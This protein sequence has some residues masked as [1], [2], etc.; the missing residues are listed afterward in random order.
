MMTEI[1]LRCDQVAKSIY[2]VY[3]VDLI[4]AMEKAMPAAEVVLRRYELNSEMRA[5]K[6]IQLQAALKRNLSPVYI[7]LQKLGHSRQK[8]ITLFPQL[9]K[10]I[11]DKGIDWGGCV[12]GGLLGYLANAH[13]LMAAASW[14]LWFFQDNDK[15][16]REQELVKQADCA[17]QEYLKGWARLY[18]LYVPVA[19][20]QMADR[21]PKPDYPA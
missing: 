2:A 21:P 3:A 7:E 5:H 19:N 17:F 11:G 13:P 9:K 6:E 15:A 18:K 14:V 10:I 1:A 12:R 8:M 20:D 16:K 4:P